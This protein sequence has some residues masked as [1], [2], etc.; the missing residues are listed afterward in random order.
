MYRHEYAD[1]VDPGLGVLTVPPILSS[2]THTHTHTYKLGNGG[3]GT[4]YPAR[5][6]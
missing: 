1:S 4:V 2:Y 5:K 3:K 6:N